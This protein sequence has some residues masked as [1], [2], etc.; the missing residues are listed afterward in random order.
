M[1]FREGFG[2]K[3]AAVVIWMSGVKKAN[4]QAGGGEGGGTQRLLLRR[5]IGGM[6]Q[7]KHLIAESDDCT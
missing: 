6:S 3:M 2:C 1:Y 5:A 4:Q 7:N